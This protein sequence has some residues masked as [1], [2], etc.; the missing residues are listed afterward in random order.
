MSKD[1]I[2]IL[3]DAIANQI[4]AGEVIVAVSVGVHPLPSVAVTIQVPAHKPVTVVV[5]CRVQLWIGC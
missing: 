5:V 4:A 1:I 2:S 3:P